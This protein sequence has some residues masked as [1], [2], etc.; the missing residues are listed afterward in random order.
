MPSHTKLLNKENKPCTSDERPEI[1][2]DYYENKQWA[3]DNTRDRETPISRVPPWMDLPKI[4]DTEF[5]LAE[6]MFIIKK[7]KNNKSPGPDGI[8][9]EFFKYM[10]SN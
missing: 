8:P 2:A 9:T 5:T 1:L 6:L 3:I 4:R 7:L 10:N